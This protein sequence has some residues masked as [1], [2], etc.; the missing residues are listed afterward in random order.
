V[1]TGVVHESRNLLTGIL[2]FAQLGKRGIADPEKATE[3]FTEIEA[4]ALRALEI[5]EHLLAVARGPG[6]RGGDEG[7]LAPRPVDVGK[8][9]GT[10][11]A[12]LREQARAADLS[13]EVRIPPGLPK[14]RAIDRY[15]VQIL[16][17]LCLNAFQASPPGSTV[18]LEASHEGERVV[19]RVSDAGDGVPHDRREEIFRPFFTTKDE[20]TGVGLSE[21]RRMAEELGGELTLATGVDGGA[22]FCLTLLECV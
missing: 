8:P 15:L 4:E 10:V 2:S 19:I 22:T 9:I 5:F 3:L 20:G 6:P 1:V 18:R 7:R 17:N 14:V 21:S 11:R 12:L 16:L 13:L